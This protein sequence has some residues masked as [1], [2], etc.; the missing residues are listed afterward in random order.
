[1]L[2]ALSQAQ[3][4]VN[5]CDRTPQVRD[6]ILLESGASDCAT[7]TPAQL[8]S[9]TGLCFNRYS[10]V[11]LCSGYN[12]ASI[13]A[14]KSGDFAGLT[15]LQSLNLSW[16]QLRVLP[17]GVFDGLT[18]LQVLEISNNQ[19]DVRPFRNLGFYSAVDSVLP[20]GVFDD[21]AV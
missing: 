4:T 10:P 3:A 7:V 15:G 16:N 6:E 11:P 17:S 21:L 1:M 20:P 14:L 12:R 19:L 13:S 8:A 18:S 5:I 9:V 2:P